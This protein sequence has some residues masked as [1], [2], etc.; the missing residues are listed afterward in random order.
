M[1]PS[2]TRKPLRLPIPCRQ[3]RVLRDH[4]REPRC[5]DA[6]LRCASRSAVPAAR[7][8]PWVFRAGGG[9]GEDGADLDEEAEDRGHP[10]A[11][12]W[13]RGVRAIPLSRVPRRPADTGATRL[14][15]VPGGRALRVP[16]EPHRADRPPPR[17]AHD[18]A[19]RLWGAAASAVARARRG[20]DTTPPRAS[21]RRRPS[22]GRRR[23]RRAASGC[24]PEAAAASGGQQ[25]AGS[26][27]ATS[28]RRQP[29]R[30]RVRAGQTSDGAGRLELGDDAGDLAR[31]AP[32]NQVDRLTVVERLD[33]PGQPDRMCSGLHHPRPAD[34][35]SRPAPPHARHAGLSESSDAQ[36]SRGQCSAPH[37]PRHRSAHRRRWATSCGY[38][39]PL[40]PK[41]VAMP[42]V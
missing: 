6:A 18:G 15:L 9:R 29:Q 19:T 31:L 25:R 42:S 26:D 40:L 28:R 13:A 3:L 24:R 27:A 1:P 10:S 16:I 22:R 37:R 32:S 23:R 33:R 14:D 38:G 11:P 5:D 35:R 30:H 39:P 2:P 41:A 7:P 8:R 34:R 12:H 20:G 4:R 21:P 17:W 36:T